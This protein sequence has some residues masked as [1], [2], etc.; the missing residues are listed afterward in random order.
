MT[1]NIHIAQNDDAKDWDAI[2]SRSTH[3]TLFHQW[4]WL[5]IAEKHTNMKLYPLTVEKAGT[6]I[7]IFPLFVQKKG[8]V[9]MVFSPPPHAALFYLGPVLLGYDVLIQEKWETLYFDFLK[10][11]E[12]FIANEIKAQYISISLSPGLQDSRQFTWSGYNF[13]VQYDYVTDLSKG[14]EYLFGTLD[15]KQRQD[16]NRA[17]KRGI[18]VEIGG[19]KELG[20]IIDLMTDRYEQQEKII[21]VPRGYLMDIYDTFNNNIVI[22]VARYEGEIITGLI[23]LVYKDT[24]YSWI[25]NARPRIP[26]SP[27]PNDLVGWEEIKYGCDHNFKSHVTMSAAGNQ[28]LH[29]YYSTK[30]NPDLKIR[31]S[32]KKTSFLTEILERGYKNILKPVRGKMRSYELLGFISNKG[33]IV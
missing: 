27:S 21:T 10:S 4:D 33:I 17:K 2:N 11:V 30:F 5:K 6:P 16:L 20:A 13:A 19:K 23:D 18:S 12:N 8:P 26:I 9:S 1:V 15:K 28:R 32:A 25:G 24:I 29:A 14:A 22:F 31:F 3:G 7:G